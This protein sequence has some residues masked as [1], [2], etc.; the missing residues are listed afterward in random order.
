MI[1]SQ[2]LN[3]ARLQAVITFLASGT[4]NAYVSI[5]DADD[6]KLVDISLAEPLGTVA[7]NLLTITATDEAMITT[8]GTASYAKVFNGDGALG[9]HCDV[10]DLNGAGPLK[11]SQAQLYAGGYVRLVSGSLG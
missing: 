1:V 10:T 7:D 6:I 3:E 9:W 11:L 8:S 2:A 5:F 4:P